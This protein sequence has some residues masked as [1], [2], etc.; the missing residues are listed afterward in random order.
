MLFLEIVIPRVC[1]AHRCV[2][3]REKVRQFVRARAHERKSEREKTRAH[4]M[5]AQAHMLL[6]MLFLENVTL[7]VCVAHRC[8]CL[9]EKERVCVCVCACA[10]ERK[11]EQER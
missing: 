9:R 8:V 2:Y 7:L 11:R 10:R 5:R 3:L 1:V 6:E 4:S